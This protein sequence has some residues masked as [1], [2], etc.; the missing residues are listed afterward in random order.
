ME[1]TGKRKQRKHEKHGMYGT[2]LYKTWNNMISRCYCPSF[3]RFYN[4]GGRGITVCEEWRNSFVAFM[5]W[6]FANGYEEHLTLDRI[7]NDGNYEPSNC[8]WITNKEQ[9]YNKRSNRY[10]TY[11]GK[12]L[13]VKEWSDITG[14]NQRTLGLRLD[15]GWSA[16][17]ALTKGVKNVG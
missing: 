10:V 11:N 12:T 3:Q 13:T 15:K 2:K 17:Q 4:Y 8:R 7:N 6:A 1:D 5:N 14:I 16:E 9:Q